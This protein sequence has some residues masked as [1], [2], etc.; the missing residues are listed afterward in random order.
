MIYCLSCGK[1]IP[2]DSKFCTFC[3][4]P[5]PVV[6]PKQPNLATASSNWMRQWQDWVV[7]DQPPVQGHRKK[8]KTCCQPVLLC[9]NLNSRSYYKI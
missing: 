6:D 4:A 1:A 3:G 7:W 9:R 8:Y 5:A 2:A